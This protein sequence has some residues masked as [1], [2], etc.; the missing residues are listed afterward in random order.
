MIARKKVED[1][2]HCFVLEAPRDQETASLDGSSANCLQ[3]QH[4]LQQLE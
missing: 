2:D 1:Q 4:C 3:W